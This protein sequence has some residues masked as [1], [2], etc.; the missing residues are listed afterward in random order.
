MM[1]ASSASPVGS[2]I[3]SLTALLIFSAITLLVLRYYLPLRTTPAFVL[4]TVFFALW[5][6]ACIVLL[7]PI[8]LA[9]NART[10]DEATRGIWLPQRVIQTC[11]RIAYWL[12][13]TLTWF[14]LPVLAEY[15]DAGYRDPKG[16]LMYS[17]RSNAQYYAMVFGFGIIALI[18]VFASYGIHLDSLKSP[19][20]A[21]AYCWGLVLAIYLMGHGLVSI[22]RHLIRSFSISGQLRQLQSAAPRLYEQLEEAE[23]NLEDLEVQVAELCRRKTGSAIDFQDWIEELMDSTNL[24]EEQPRTTSAVSSGEARRVPTVITEKYMAEL[25]RELT[26]ARHARSRYASEWNRLLRKAAETRAILDSGGSKKLEFGGTAPHAS[27]WERMSVLTPYSRHVLHFHIMPH[28]R[29]FFGGILALA[30]IFIVWSEIIKAGPTALANLSIIRLTVVHHWTGDK[31]Q[32]GFAGQMIAAFWIS[33]MCAA[34][35]I[36]ITEVKVWRGR[37]LVYRNTSH[38]SALWYSSY[39]ARLSVPLSYNFISFL[40]KDVYQKTRFYDFLGRLIDLTALGSWFNRLFPLFVLLPISATMF[41]LYGKV[42]R[43]I[44]LADYIDDDDDENQT[45]YG[46]GSWRE[47]RDLIERELNGTSIGRSRDVA[48]PGGI[49]SGGAATRATPVRSIPGPSSRPGGPTTPL[50]TSPNIGRVESP[51]TAAS[52][53]RVGQRQHARLGDDED[54]D[55]NFFSQLGTRI[56]NTVD[57][58]DTPNWLQEIV[59]KPKWMGGDDDEGGQASG[60]GSNSSDIRRWFGGG[61]D[62]RIRL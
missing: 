6:P 49:A 57:T 58:I 51:A 59:K 50:G 28:V 34:A 37:A 18:Y 47:G 27:W 21:L 35:L 15:S 30:S 16:K 62:G 14:I 38:E 44:G 31:G 17:L 26:R 24:P 29:L 39:V 25:T 8:D 56:K 40:S 46:T 55:D 54:E 7:V 43:T 1:I 36:S 33:Y 11:W 12:T 20:M 23:M 53:R 60:S 3:F 45:G 2:E 52:S 10:D 32:V 61:N 4:V 19:V 9:S 5:L 48:G 13:F 41:G 42:K 22:P